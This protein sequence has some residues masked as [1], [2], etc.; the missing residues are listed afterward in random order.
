[1]K[2]ITICMCF[3]FL[4]VAATISGATDITYLEG[5]TLSDGSICQLPAIFSYTPEDRP[6]LQ[7]KEVNG[8]PNNRA[9]A[10]VGTLTLVG[11]NSGTQSAAFKKSGTNVMYQL[12]MAG[13][14]YGNNRTAD[15][16][17][18]Q[19]FR[20]NEAKYTVTVNDK[21]GNGSTTT[22]LNLRLWAVFDGKNKTGI[23]L[24][25]TA[26]T[27]VYKRAKEANFSLLLGGQYPDSLYGG[28][29][30]SL[31]LVT[32]EPYNAKLQLDETTGNI[33][34]R[35]QDAWRDVLR[36]SYRINRDYPNKSYT[37]RHVTT[38]TS[39][40]FSEFSMYLLDHGLNYNVAPGEEAYTPGW[41]INISTAAYSAEEYVNV[42]PYTD[43]IQNIA[44]VTLAAEDNTIGKTYAVIYSFSDST[45]NAAG[46]EFAL[47]QE[48][49]ASTKTIPYT[50]RFSPHGSDPIVKG[51]EY[52]WY[53]KST[54]ESAKMSISDLYTHSKEA[55]SGVW[56]DTITITFKAT[57]STGLTKNT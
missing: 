41:I 3:L 30:I 54:P 47:K 43:S 6:Y 52:I 38:L 17:A 35:D 36:W 25:Q 7:K 12:Y 4:S 20:N 42:N 49:S 24:S 13:G 5:E 57:D 56:K 21:N 50:L 8:I 29:T 15:D 39:R 22:T 19:N 53:V 2:R 16:T 10:K 48:G 37:Y 27:T 32:E 31:Y 44:D 55:D 34:L 1:M 28:D 26:S 45:D 40:P 11:W 51:H 9:I 18:D 33:K 46:S 23:D 14:E